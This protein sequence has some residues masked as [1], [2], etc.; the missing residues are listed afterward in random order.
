MKERKGRIVLFFLSPKE[1]RLSL[2][3]IIIIIIKIK[4]FFFG[5]REREKK[6]RLMMCLRLLFREQKVCYKPNRIK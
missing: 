5:G 3:I 6:L 2:K 1:S 4:N